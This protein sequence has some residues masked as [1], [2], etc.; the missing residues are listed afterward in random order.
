MTRGALVGREREVD[1][2]AGWLD[3]AVAGEPR[4]VL[5]GGE[6][7]VGKTRLAEELAELAGVRQLPVLWGRAVEADGSPP[8]WPWR[9]VLRS[10]GRLGGAGRIAADLRVTADLAVLA[11]EVFPGEEGAVEAASLEQ[12]FRAFDAVTRFLRELAAP[13]GLVVVLDDVHWADRPSLLLLG[14]LVR[15]LE[16]GRLLVLATYR[17][18]EPAR[19]CASSE[20]GMPWSGALCVADCR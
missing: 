13:R 12:R 5:C 10:P 15:D 9:Q 8:Y 3:A 18:T 19:A 20:A 2:L 6:P 7:G 11:P 14:H 16:P 4:L 1:A 17:H